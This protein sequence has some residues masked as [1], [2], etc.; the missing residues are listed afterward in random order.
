MIN[1]GLTPNVVL[2][3]LMTIS[4]SLFYIVKITKPQISGTNDIFVITLNLIYSGIIIIHGWR[5]DPILL[6]SQYIIVTIV[7]FFTIDNINLKN[8]ILL[9][10]R[11]KQRKYGQQKRREYL[12]Q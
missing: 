12:E 9:V 5:L 7:M 4:G 1:I 6:F 2:G 10:K 11:R 3:I 8:Q